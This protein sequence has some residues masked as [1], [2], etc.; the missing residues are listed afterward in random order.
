[1]GMSGSVPYHAEIFTD[2]NLFGYNIKHH[3]CYMIKEPTNTFK[4]PEITA[5]LG[6][7]VLYRLPPIC[8]DW[9]SRR[10]FILP[11][12]HQNLQPHLSVRPIVDHQE[13]SHNFVHNPYIPQELC[14]NQEEF[15]RR[16]ESISSPFNDNNPKNYAPEIRDKTPNVKDATKIRKQPLN[17]NRNPAKQWR[18]ERRA[19]Y[20]RLK[21]LKRMSSKFI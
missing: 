1:M 17:L 2:I 7:D 13:P 3:H 6:T 16:C 21:E 15:D 8:F 9:Q 19:F 18:K 10:I 4:D 14:V 11:R 20:I 12:F 5:I